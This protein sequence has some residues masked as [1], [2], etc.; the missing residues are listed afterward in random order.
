MN[1]LLLILFLTSTE[2]LSRDFYYS[3]ENFSLEQKG[4]YT[5]IN[6]QNLQH[7]GRDNQP[8][9]PS[10]NFSLLLPYNAEVEN[11][12]ITASNPIV[13]GKAEI[14]LYT[15]PANPFSTNQRREGF[16]N[17]EIYASNNLYPDKFLVSNHYGN[18]SGF[19][20]IG[21]II[22][23][24]KWDPVSKD[25]ILYEKINLSINYKRSGNIKFNTVLRDKLFRKI[26]SFT[27]DNPEKINIWSPPICDG[28]IDYLIVAPN[29][30]LQT[31]AIDSLISLK[32][33]D[34]LL[35][36]TISI[37][38]INST[39]T[40]NDTP[41]KLRN[42]LIQRHQQDG[43]TYALLVGDKEILEPREI[44]TAAYDTNGSQYPDSS[45]SDLYFADLDGDWNYNVDNR[46]G[47]PDDSLDLYADIIVGRLPVK[48]S[49]DL[50]NIIK[51]IFIYQTEA[52]TGNWRTT[53]ILAGAILFQNYSYTGEAC[54]ESIALRLPTSWHNIKMYEPLPNGPAPV[55]TID[56]LNN[57]VAWTQWCGHGN[58]WG[59][60]WDDWNENMLLYTD[61][62]QMN[63]GGKLAVHTSIACM[64]GA[65]HNTCVAEP[66]MNIRNGGAIICTFN[67]TYGWEGYLAL[68]E[69]GPS[70]FMDIWFAESVFDSSMSILGQA[71]Y[72]SKG[73]RVSY[74]DHTFYNGYDRNWTTI[75]SLT[76]FGDPSLEFIGYQ[77]S[78]EE[79]P[80]ILNNDFSF[81]FNNKMLSI[82]S[83]GNSNINIFDVTGRIIFNENFRDNFSKDLTNYNSGRYFCIIRSE[84]KTY[85]KNL[86]IL[87]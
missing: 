16:C 19:K 18:Q 4:I 84:N 55:G 78:V 48:N 43:L 32:I 50:S 73:R 62:Q 60:F 39:M 63:N 37:E 1:L 87:N 29:I 20:I 47:Q 80:Q 5:I 79:A 13:I 49:S 14:P 34:G 81:M 69:M 57:G 38:T 77:S 3:S 67:T 24:V 68:G 40:G 74:W 83:F 45:P 26:V 28:N 10:E 70:E 75:L 54:C 59:V 71:F 44:W 51:K 15:D 2:N 25:I 76:F 65:F 42:Y 9:L 23:P 8:L 53:S 27:V 31:Q 52:P 30:L 21:G 11:I 72:A 41:E 86:I 58:D 36:D 85:Y 35:T 56:S 46:Y 66:L 12:E 33:S 82:Q 64:P 61:V 6:S 7:F 22:V 17:P